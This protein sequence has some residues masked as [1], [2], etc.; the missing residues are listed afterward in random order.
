MSILV[1]SIKERSMVRDVRSLNVVT[2]MLENGKMEGVQAK[3][4]TNFQMDVV[5]RVKFGTVSHT[6]LDS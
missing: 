1:I 6:G 5:T 4:A 2:L 3:A